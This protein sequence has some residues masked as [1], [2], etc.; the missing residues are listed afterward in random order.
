MYEEYLNSADGERVVMNIMNRN[1]G[2][3]DLI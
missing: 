3:E 1:K 2:G